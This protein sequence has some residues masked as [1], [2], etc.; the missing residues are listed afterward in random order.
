MLK[1][2]SIWSYFTFFYSC[3]CGLTHKLWFQ[4]LGNLQ[5]RLFLRSIFPMFPILTNCKYKTMLNVKLSFRIGILT[6][7]KL[8]NSK[9]NKNKFAFFKVSNYKRNPGASQLGKRWTWIQIYIGKICQRTRH[10]RHEPS[11]GRRC[12][13][14]FEM[15]MHKAGQMPPLFGLRPLCAEIWS[16]LSLVW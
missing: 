7:L 15:L 6:S 1:R 3:S 8:K 16:S 5:N 9:Q 10:S 11:Y 4:Q 13:I 2:W 14:L 12:S